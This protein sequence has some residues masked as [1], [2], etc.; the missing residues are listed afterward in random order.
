[1]LA[2]TF[3]GATDAIRVDLN[4]VEESEGRIIAALNA[5][6]PD[7]RPLQNLVAAN[8]RVTL[9]ETP[10]TISEV[11]SELGA[12]AG[13]SIVLVVDVSG[14]MTGD[15]ISQAKRALTEFVRGLES[16]DRVAVLAF[17]TNVVMIQDFTT[18]RAQLEGAVQRLTPKGDTALYDAVVEGLRKVKEAPSGRRQLVLLSDGV[19]SAGTTTREESLVQAREAGVGI[20]SV[21]LGT[22]IDRAYLEE[23]S[24]ASA[25]YFV[26]TQSPTALRQAYAD[27][28]AAIRNQFTL[29]LLVPPG[30]DR[31][32]QGKLSIRVSSRQDVGLVEYSLQPLPG[33]VPPPFELALQGAPKAGKLKGPAAITPS[34][35]QGIDPVSVEYLVDDEVVHTATS[36]PF[37]LDLRPESYLEGTHILKAV[38]RDGRGR[39][40]T[41]QLPFTVPAASSGGS[42]ISIPGFVP[43]LLALFALAG[44][45]AYIII[46]RRAS[47]ASG[48]VA[49]RIKPFAVRI[50]EHTGPVQGWPMPALKPPPARNENAPLGQVVVMD[51]VAIRAGEL[52]SIREYEIGT[53]PLTLG[54]GVNCDVR[55]EDPE[56]RIAGEEARLWVQKGRLVYHKLTTLSAMATEGVTSGWQVLES[57]EEIE[58]GPYRI[59]Y[60]A[61]EIEEEP[62]Q[63]A[64]ASSNIPPDEI[65]Y[66]RELW[67]RVPDDPPLSAA[68]DQNL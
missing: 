51:P 45:V 31:S 24:R 67:T 28:A 20:V 41:A 43:V 27:I 21:G 11:Q 9:D 7:G 25:G 68:S 23:L 32:L 49:G 13:A 35:P 66:F 37:G 56:D 57:G 10:L 18:N 46:R 44:G 2:T 6:A 50:T 5:Y 58:V 48:S 54:T 34:I 60:Q 8:F 4:S 17:D 47:G 40:G 64:A 22:E 61:Y 63:A 30:V 53:S 16:A 38:V 42:G 19:T 52:E 33:A 55:L 29:T 14:S 1:M 12:R 62:V 36:A 59:L 65:S 39:Q 15:P 3:A 26:E